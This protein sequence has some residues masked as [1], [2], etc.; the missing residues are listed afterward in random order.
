MGHH[1][2]EQHDDA[3]DDG[4]GGVGTPLQQMLSLRMMQGVQWA[5]GISEL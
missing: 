5:G 1:G 2:D 3:D 4:V